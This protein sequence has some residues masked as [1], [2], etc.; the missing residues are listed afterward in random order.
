MKTLKRVSALLNAI[1]IIGAVVGLY[2]VSQQPDPTQF[3]DYLNYG[4]LAGVPLMIVSDLLRGGN[5]GYQYLLWFMVGV[6]LFHRPVTQW[7]LCLAGLA[8]FGVS[9]VLALMMINYR[10]GAKP[11]TA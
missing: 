7:T 3:W 8:I 5:G 4:M 6:E 10:K 2:W 11:S 1:Y 9:L